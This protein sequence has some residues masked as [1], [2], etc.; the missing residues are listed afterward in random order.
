MPA[1]APG[2]LSVP[3]ASCFAAAGMRLQPTILRMPSAAESK[4]AM[5]PVLI[6]FFN[7]YSLRSNPTP[8]AYKDRQP[9]RAPAVRKG[10]ASAWL[11]QV[12]P[13]WDPG[14]TSASC[15]GCWEARL[16]YRCGAPSIEEVGQ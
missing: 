8:G 5:E 10:R 14:A 4:H 11:F 9:H 13:L 15:R 16:R 12:R 6:G 7:C 1:L 2:I 3:A